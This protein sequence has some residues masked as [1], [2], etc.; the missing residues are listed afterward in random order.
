M[1]VS[2]MTG[3][4]KGNESAQVIWSFAP[5][6]Q[7]TYDHRVS[8][9]LYDPTDE[10]AAAAAAQLPPLASTTLMSTAAPTAGASTQEDDDR[11]HEI[12]DDDGGDATGIAEEDTRKAAMSST[13]PP[14]VQRSAP[15]LPPGI[16]RV[17]LHV[18]GEGTSGALAMDPPSLDLG[19]LAVGHAITRTITLINQSDGVLRYLMDCGPEEGSDGDGTREPGSTPVE[20]P[21]AGLSNVDPKPGLEIWVDEPEGA[22]PAKASKVVSVTFFPRFRKQYRLQ[23]RCRTSTVVPSLS[24]APARP[25]SGGAASRAVLPPLSTKQRMMNGSTSA[26]QLPLGSLTTAVLGSIVTAGGPEAISRWPESAPA[27]CS[28]SAAVVFPWLMVTDVLLEGIPKQVT[29]DMMGVYDIN[30]ELQKQVTE[31]ELELNSV[32]KMLKLGRF[33][34][35]NLV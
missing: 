12:R 10:A 16:D 13:A 7:K 35:I 21:E 33:N 14:S 26:S 17:M 31:L 4:L 34:V 8:C 9:L 32:R 24:P 23:V 18:L 15:S 2:P 28:L 29:W 27:I 22:I 25:P 5:G 1:S 6:K 19:T 3:I 11:E 20:F 30:N